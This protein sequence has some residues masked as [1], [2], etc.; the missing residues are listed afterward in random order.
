MQGVVPSLGLTLTN[1]TTPS[2]ALLLGGYGRA[3]SLG[4]A[5]AWAG[6]LGGLREALDF[7][8]PAGVPW[9]EGSNLASVV[10]D[11]LGDVT[12]VAYLT[13]VSRSWGWAQAFSPQSGGAADAGLAPDAMI[14]G[15]AAV[16]AMVEG[17]SQGWYGQGGAAAPCAY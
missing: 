2:N 15:T 3:Q 14:Y 9:P 11:A 5:G 12:Q 4:A 1:K 17:A 6:E 16:S 8:S 13:A 10:T 7:T